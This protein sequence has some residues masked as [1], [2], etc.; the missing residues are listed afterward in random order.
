M[1]KTKTEHL[2]SMSR[3]Q[4]EMYVDA[5]DNCDQDLID[6][7]TELAA[8]KKKL[9]RADWLSGIALLAINEMICTCLNGI[10]C[11]RCQLHEA[12]EAYREV[13]SE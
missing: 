1:D 13:G 11:G 2:L 6:L 12:V 10:L 4:I 5:G 3:E 7:H 9:A 8:T